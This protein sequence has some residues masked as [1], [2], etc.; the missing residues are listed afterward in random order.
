MPIPKGI[1]I[2]MLKLVRQY[3]YHH[4]LTKNLILFKQSIYNYNTYVYIAESRANEVLIILVV[5]G[6]CPESPHDQG[7]RTD[8]L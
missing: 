1:A 5:V 2:I 3:L 4:T 6:F 8:H 7:K